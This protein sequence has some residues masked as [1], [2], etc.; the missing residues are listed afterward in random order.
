MQ[1]AGSSAWQIVQGYSTSATY[2]WNTAGAAAGTEHFGVWVRDAAGVAQ[3]D[4]YASVPYT[5]FSAC[6][7]VSES[8][9]P[10]SPLA[11][12]TGATV[13]ISAAASGCANPVY[14][15]WMRPAGSTAWQPV[16][17]YSTSATYSWNTKGAAAGTDYFGVWVRDAASSAANDA[18]TSAKYTLS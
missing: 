16:Q 3:Y 18:Y 10:V 13:T 2:R 7:S 6:T 17:G 14:E 8:F 1:P 5:L 11:H 4:T 12:G 9:S 15:F